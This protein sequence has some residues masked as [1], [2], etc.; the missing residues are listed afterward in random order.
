MLEHAVAR[1]LRLADR[2]PADGVAREVELDQLAARS[3]RAGRGAR[4]PARCRTATGR[5]P[6]CAPPG[7]AAPSASCAPWPRPP[8][9]AARRPGGHSSK[10]MRCR[11]R[12]CCWISIER[13]G[14]SRCGEPSRWLG[15]ARP[16]RRACAGRR[17]EDLVAAAVGEERAVPAGEAVQAAELGDQRVAG[18]QHQV[19]GVGEQDAGRRS[20]AGRGAVTAL[21]A[22]AV[23]TGMKIGVSTSP[24]GVRSR[25][26]RARGRRARGP[27][28]RSRPWTRRV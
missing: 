7:S 4:R 16:P 25:P 18:A 15:S 12:G 23:P 26:A 13:S 8:P 22:P 21:T 20:R 1:R 10:A 27:R 9:R 24:W 3:S 11:R 28:R 17:A 14:E 5:C 6:S 19:V 2:E